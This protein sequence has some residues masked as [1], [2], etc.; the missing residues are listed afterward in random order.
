VTRPR[1]KIEGRRSVDRLLFYREDTGK[2]VFPITIEE[3]LNKQID[4][5]YEEYRTREELVCD[6][7]AE[8][9][10]IV[11][12]LP[13]NTRAITLFEEDDQFGHRRIMR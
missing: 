9:R 13:E 8:L 7:V 6:A 4:R 12:A 3:A 5:L 11:D 2:P 10:L 1:V